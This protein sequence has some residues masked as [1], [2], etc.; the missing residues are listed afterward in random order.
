IASAGP[1]DIASLEGNSDSWASICSGMR[2]P[3]S[4][5]YKTSVLTLIRSPRSNNCRGRGANG[6]LPLKVS[7]ST[8]VSRWIIPSGFG[9][10]R[11][12]EQRGFLRSRHPLLSGCEMVCVPP[13]DQITSTCALVPLHS[14]GRCER[15]SPGSLHALQHS[16]AFSTLKRSGAMFQPFVRRR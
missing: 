16:E 13:F 2:G 15:H 10:H 3:R 4:H 12:C 1:N 9:G 7:I 14:T 5:S 8:D 6:F 11:F